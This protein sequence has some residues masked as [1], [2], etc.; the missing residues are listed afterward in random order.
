MFVCVRVFRVCGIYVCVKRNKDR[1]E[2]EHKGVFV[3]VMCV[4]LECAVYMYV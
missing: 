2:G 4:C 3:C 1:S